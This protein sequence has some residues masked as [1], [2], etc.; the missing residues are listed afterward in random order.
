MLT[1]L[2]VVVDIGYKSGKVYRRYRSRSVLDLDADKINKA[3]SSSTSE[4]VRC[5]RCRREENRPIERL[6][7]GAKRRKAYRGD[8]AQGKKRQLYLP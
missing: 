6:L 1:D 3:M 2:N 4:M 5:D 8:E 7:K